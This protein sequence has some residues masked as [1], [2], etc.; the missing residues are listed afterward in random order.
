M[1]SLAQPH[2]VVYQ[3]LQ[4]RHGN[5]VFIATDQGE[6]GKVVAQRKKGG[7]ELRDIDATVL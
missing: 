1:A 6:L 5:V 2:S 7:I 3:G 4:N